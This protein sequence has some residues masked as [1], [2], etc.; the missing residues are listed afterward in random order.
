MNNRKVKFGPAWVLLGVLGVA[1][2]WCAFVSTP[3]AL[4]SSCDCNAAYIAAGQFC[5]NHFGEP[6][7]WF[8]CPVTQNGTS[9]Y[10]YECEFQQQVYGGPCPS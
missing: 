4:A 3:T 5:E 6:V 10:F 1:L 8:E 2:A 9:V 7:S